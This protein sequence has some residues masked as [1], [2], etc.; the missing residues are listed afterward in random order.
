MGETFKY[1]KE[2][3]FPGKSSSSSLSGCKSVK[4]YA[5]GGKAECAKGGKTI[6]K[7]MAKQESS[8]LESVST[9]RRHGKEEVG[10]A[11]SLKRQNKVVVP[12]TPPK[13]AFNREPLIPIP[14]MKAGGS[15]GSK[16]QAKIGKVMREFK[17]GELHSGSKKGSKVTNRR[18]AIAI[19]LSEARKASRQK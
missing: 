15:V 16:E 13:V 7:G 11:H 3:E 2:F 18:Q 10:E 14:P 8:E 6:P 12:V 1:V 17:S 5:R 4:G 19:S 9:K